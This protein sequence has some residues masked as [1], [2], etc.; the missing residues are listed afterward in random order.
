MKYTAMRRGSN[1]SCMISENLFWVYKIDIL[2]FFPNFWNNNCIFS[3][4][5]CTKATTQE[6]DPALSPCKV[7]MALEITSPVNI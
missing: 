7:S 6:V 2:N 4:I 3:N 5:C 1:A